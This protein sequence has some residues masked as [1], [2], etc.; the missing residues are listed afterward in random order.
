MPLARASTGLRLPYRS[1]ITLR[2]FPMLS[3]SL[4]PS[5]TRPSLQLPQEPLRDLSL[6]FLIMNA[7]FR[8]GVAST[9]VAASLLMVRP[10]G[11]QDAAA[12][13]QESA[14]PVAPAWQPNLTMAVGDQQS[15]A[16]L[17]LITGPQ[18]AIYQIKGVPA[19]LTLR[20]VN[21][22]SARDYPVTLGAISPRD[23]TYRGATADFRLRMIDAETAMV[24]FH[25]SNDSKSLAM[26]EVRTDT[27]ATTT[28]L[29]PSFGGISITS[30][31]GRTVNFQMVA[32]R[33]F[34]TPR[35]N[36]YDLVARLQ[37]NQRILILI[38]TR[39]K[40]EEEIRSL[41]TSSVFDRSRRPEEVASSE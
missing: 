38:S 40:S 18:P 32:P 1:L 5:G 23:T 36:G 35:R 4:T 3:P 10:A 39:Q 25:T 9:L 41:Q 26:L 11:A 7:L 30:S 15:T 12:P 22:E 33:P 19:Q 6:E 28:T 29:L 24:E 2:G 34:R 16:S 8:V 13:V 21:P 31:E 37:P 14:A 27:T 17:A 20:I